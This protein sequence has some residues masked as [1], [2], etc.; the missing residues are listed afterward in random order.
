MEN[1]ISLEERENR[2]DNEFFKN[3]RELFLIFLACSA[4]VRF[5]EWL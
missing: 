1:E 5:F 4:I 2:E 3:I